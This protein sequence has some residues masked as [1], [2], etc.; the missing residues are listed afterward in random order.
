MLLFLYFTLFVL[1]LAVFAWSW[2]MLYLHL[3]K[4]RVE[5][6]QIWLGFLWILGAIILLVATPLLLHFF[7]AL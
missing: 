5:N 6:R 7:F 4:R 3:N 1:V 2:G